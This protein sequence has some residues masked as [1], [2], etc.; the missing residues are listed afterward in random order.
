MI[1]FIVLIAGIVLL[2][3]MGIKEQTEW[4]AFLKA[5]DCKIISHDA[6]S[7]QQGIWFG[8]TGQP[9]VLVMPERAKTGWLCNDGVTYWR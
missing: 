5:H 3:I 2:I 4:A 8:A 9:G 7:M 1:A 6:G